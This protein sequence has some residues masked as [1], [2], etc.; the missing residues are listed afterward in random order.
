MAAVEAGL[1]CGRSRGEAH[2][3]ALISSVPGAAG[4]LKPALARSSLQRLAKAWLLSS[5]ESS[6]R[7]TLPCKPHT[8]ITSACHGF[9]TF[10]TVAEVTLSDC[11]VE[12][13]GQG[14]DNDKM[15][16]T[17][18]SVL[19]NGKIHS[20]AEDGFYSWRDATAETDESKR[21][22]SKGA[23]SKQAAFVRHRLTAAMQAGSLAEVSHGIRCF[24][25]Y[26]AGWEKL[27]KEA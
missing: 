10:N 5:P 22:R 19:Q 18:D 11:E 15:R 26:T 9:S 24:A 12:G 25:T 7:L 23:S 2:W 21:S 16:I 13:D 17:T 20:P 4:T 6:R 27:L 3:P 14:L 1:Q 8:H